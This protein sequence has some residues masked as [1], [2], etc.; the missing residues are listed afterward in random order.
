MDYFVFNGI[1]SRD[2]G[3]YLD[4]P[5]VY[6]SAKRRTETV[7]IP[8]RNGTVTIDS[9]TF[10]NV[11]AEYDCYIREDLQNKL[12]A[13]RE[14]ISMTGDYCRIE[15]TFEPEYYMNARCVG[16]ISMDVLSAMHTSGTFSI[17]FD[18][19]PERWLKSG[20]KAVQFTAEGVIYNPTAYEAK[21]IIR[22]YGTGNVRVGNSNITVTSAGTNYI[23]IDT[24]IMEAYEGTTNRNNCITAE[25]VYGG[26]PSGKNTVTFTGF[27]RVEITPRWW[28][29]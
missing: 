8:G 9:G 25:S 6:N 18:C 13:F 1:D 5:S 29:V 26:I 12:P 17:N 28:T 27:R 21:P 10:D 16:G 4:A 22:V 11:I 14:K 3:I 19:K 2:Y 7:V 24:D 23:D 20:E 15:N